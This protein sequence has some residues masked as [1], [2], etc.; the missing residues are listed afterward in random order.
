MRYP[1]QQAEVVGLVDH[2]ING[3]TGHPDMFPHCDTALLQTSREEFLKAEVDFNQAKTQFAQVAAVKQEKFRNMQQEMKRQ[4]KFGSADNVNTP[5]NLSFIG[6]GPKRPPTQLEIPGSP[7]NL[8][9]AAQSNN[10][11]ICLIWGK[12]R[13]GGP[14][15]S[16]IIERKIFNRSWNEWHFVGI[17]FNNEIKLTKQPIGVK[18]DY[19][20]CA[21]NASGT[22]MPTNTVAV[23]L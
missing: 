4:I 13:N 23:V 11:T 15:R 14:V 17:S 6:W 1:R 8:K 22:S 3:V 10:G 12:S 16:Y 2:I 20:V 19:Q 21:G 5:E 9:I 18:L 7:T